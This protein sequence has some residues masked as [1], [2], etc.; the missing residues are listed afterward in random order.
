MD[1]RVSDLITRESTLSCELRE[2]QTV[3]GATVEQFEERIRGYEERVREEKLKSGEMDRKLDDLTQQII[4]RGKL[5][6]V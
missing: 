6:Q 5:V 3:H 4:G 2:E 1:A